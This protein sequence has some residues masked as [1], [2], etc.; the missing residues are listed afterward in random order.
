[1]PNKKD[2]TSKPPIAEVLKH[3]FPDI[4]EIAPRLGEIT[5]LCPFHDDTVPSGRA[6]TKHQV[7]FCHACGKGG[8]SWQIIME[9]EGV[10]FAEAVRLAESK[11]KFTGGSLRKPAH[12]RGKRY[13]PSW[14]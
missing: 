8:D 9:M 14:S 11:F 10:E 6:N 12:P 7:Y 3:Y 13:E 5:L 2:E 1:M 4:G